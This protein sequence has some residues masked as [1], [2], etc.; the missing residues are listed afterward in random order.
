MELVAVLG[1]TE[2]VVVLGAADLAVVLGAAEL[3]VVLGAAKPFVV[4]GIA[5]FVVVVGTVVLSGFRMARHVLELKAAMVKR[6]AY[7]VA[8][9][10][11]W[12]PGK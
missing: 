9:A 4:H 5:D 8:A 2:L 3:V 1:A 7:L 6:A 12:L 11:V 10:Y